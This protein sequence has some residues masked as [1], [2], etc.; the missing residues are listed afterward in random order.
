[1]AILINYE[2]LRLEPGP[3]VM[4]CLE[5]VSLSRHSSGPL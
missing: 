4:L 1:L 2:N 5:S 3:I